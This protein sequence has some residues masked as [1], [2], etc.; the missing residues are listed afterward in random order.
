MEEK[1]K[2]MRER[3]SHQA[4]TVVLPSGGEN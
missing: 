3:K 4:D 1:K 2:K